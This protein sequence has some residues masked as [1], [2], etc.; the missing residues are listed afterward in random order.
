MVGRLQNPLVLAESETRL[1]R[2]FVGLCAATILAAPVACLDEQGP[3]AFTTANTCYVG[4]TRPCDCEDE[5]TG[6]QT[7]LPEG[8][9]SDECRCPGCTVHPDCKGCEPDDCFNTCMCQTGGIYDPL[10]CEDTCAEDPGADD[11]GARSQALR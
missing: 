2:R 8:V 4:E 1:F 3:G 9:F 7:C 10:V 11:A 6:V 5:A